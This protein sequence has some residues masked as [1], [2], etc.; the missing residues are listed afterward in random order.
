M[1]AIIRQGSRQY[2]V[3]PGDKIQIELIDAEDGSTVTLD[4]VLAVQDGEKMHLGAPVLGGASVAAKVLRS[5]RGEKVRIFTYKRRKG[6]EKR[7]GHRQPFLE[8]EIESINLNGKALSK[9]A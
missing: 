7:K 1:Y 3:S 6:F 2:R 9:K 8:L 4:N 5:G